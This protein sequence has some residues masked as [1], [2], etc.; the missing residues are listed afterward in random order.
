MYHIAGQQRNYFW[1]SVE[2]GTSKDVRDIAKR[3]A[4]GEISI[5]HVMPQTLTPAWQDELGPHAEEIHEHWLHRI[6][7]LTV[8][9]YNSEYSN[10][11]F[12]AKREAEEGFAHSPYRVNKQIANAERWGLGQ[13]E[14]RTQE[15]VEIASRI[16]TTPTNSFSPPANSSD[17]VPLGE[18]EDF[19]GRVIKAWEFQGVV[20]PVSSWKQALLE[21]VR[22]L[23]DEDAVAFRQGARHTGGGIRYDHPDAG[24]EYLYTEALPG[25]LVYC[26]SSTPSK[27]GIMRNL[28]HGMGLE[29]DDLLFHLYP[30]EEDTTTD[31]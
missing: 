3:L 1:E 28:F 20:H 30:L 27:V 6:G 13:M 29:T 4:L 16:W 12:Q 14:A 21:L 2:N 15:L 26:Q 23:H 9:G 18:D 10:R 31:E 19:K 8:T 24:Y 11:S 17:A 25:M 7:N 22:H 5:E